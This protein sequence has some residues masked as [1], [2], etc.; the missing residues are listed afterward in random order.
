MIIE[1]YGLP[2]AGKTTVAQKLA[3]KSDFK[4]IK[5]RSKKE[6]FWYNFLFL[7]RHPVRFF[8]TLFYLVA[9]SASWSIFYYKFTNTFLHHNAKYQK[10]IGMEKAILDQGYFQ[11]VLSVFEE[12]ISASFL[13]KYAGFLLKPDKLVILNLPPDDILRRIGG[14]G[15]MTRERFGQKYFEKWLEAVK[16][17][18]RIF[19]ENLD[20]LGID[21]II[22]DAR[23]G[24]GDIY[25]EVLGI[26]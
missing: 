25:K 14:R 23:R 5:I 9:N 7:I 18:N 16:E 10:A 12:P 17:N 20:K 24:V 4:V 1:F 15:Y 2:G 22:I 8:A 11:N 26:L 21:Y 19:L 6:L 13:V 3:A